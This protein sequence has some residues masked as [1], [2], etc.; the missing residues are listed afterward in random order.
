MQTIVSDQRCLCWEYLKYDI[1]DVLIKG[2]P[3][4]LLQCIKRCIGPDEVAY[5][6]C[7]YQIAY[8][9]AYQVAYQIRIYQMFLCVALPP[10]KMD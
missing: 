8:Q 2:I 3:T 10:D 7:I 1:P 5:Q 9:I 6:I 4:L